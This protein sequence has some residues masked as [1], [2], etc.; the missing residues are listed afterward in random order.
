M[1]I[2]PLP[3][4]VLLLAIA[5]G[6]HEKTSP[7]NW[8]TLVN[9]PVP[10]NFKTY[11]YQGKAEINSYRLEQSRYGENRSG[12]AILVFVTEDFSK[13][14]QVK[15]D[16]PSKAGKDKV[17][18]MKLNAIRK[19]KTGIY[20]YSM[21][22]STFTPVEVQEFPHSL[23]ST[24]SSQ[25]WCGHTFTQLNLEN[26]D[27]K[28]REF[29]YFESEGDKIYTTP[30]VLL[31]DELWTR[32]R[33]NPG[34]IPTGTA[35]LLPGGIHARLGHG[36]L[37][38]KKARIQ[39]EK[40]QGQSK[41]IVEYLHFDRT[42]V[43]DFETGFPHRILSWSEDNGKGRFGG[44]LTKASLRKSIKSAYWS[45]NSNAFAGLRDTLQLSY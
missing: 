19:F 6:C 15:L 45:K 36:E 26:K 43:I 14:K 34:S 10:D 40:G 18:V 29:S 39:L 7:A 2:F 1:K 9:S 5:Y 37:K 24:T 21:M 38:P 12:D 3:L 32:I 35:D 30:K 16:D 13:S 28:I 42:L 41:L 27:F 25:E 8:A 44:G 22:Q 23:K 31:E 17:S 33:I 20:D 4:V 11:W